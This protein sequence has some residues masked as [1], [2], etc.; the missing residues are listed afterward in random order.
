MPYVRV[1][2]LGVPADD[3]YECTIPK[4]T[5]GPSGDLAETPHHEDGPP[6]SSMPP[7]HNPAPPTRRASAM[8]QWIV[9][10]T[11]QQLAHETQRKSIYQI[12]VVVNSRSVPP[13]TLP[14]IS[15]LTRFLPEAPCSGPSRSNTRYTICRQDRSDTVTIGTYLAIKLKGW[16]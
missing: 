7:S 10:G 12:F 9:R 2:S 11:L 3:T 15:P 16:R 4:H 5:L 8:F 6:R 1:C 14:G 13:G